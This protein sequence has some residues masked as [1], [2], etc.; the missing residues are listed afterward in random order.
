MIIKKD[1]ASPVSVD[2]IQDKHR[3]THSV[4]DNST[5][6]PAG[7]AHAT[8]ECAASIE[9]RRKTRSSTASSAMHGRAGQTARSKIAGHWTTVEVRSAIRTHCQ[10]IARA[11]LRGN[12]LE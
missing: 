12:S 10:L 5:F 2:G 11:R 9:R 3:R 4:E 7:L 8:R 6:H 1:L